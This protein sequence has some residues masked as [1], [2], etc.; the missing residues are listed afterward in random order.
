VEALDNI[1]SGRGGA[2]PAPEPTPVEEPKPVETTAPTEPQD[3][4]IEHQDGRKMVP[5]EAVTEARGKIKRYTEQVAAF[6]QT[7]KEREAAWDR[8]FSELLQSVKQPTP[9]PEPQQEPPDFFA[10]PNAAI[11]AALAQN[12]APLQ[13][14][15]METRTALLEERLTRIAGSEKAAKIEAEI[16][17]AMQAGDPAINALQHA[18]RTQGPAAASLLVEWYD[19]RTFDPAAEREKIKAEILAELRGSGEQPAATVQPAPV[20]PSN[21]AG[22]RNVGVRSGPAWEGPKP[23][24]DIF[25]R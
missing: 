2:T 5:L 8:R 9:Q 23:L 7:L 21:L 10:D 16:G 11:K 4:V 17:K 3:E 13:S 6:E 25:K 12:L 18:L 22:A 19:K 15:L 1:L 20:M 14:Q 24:G